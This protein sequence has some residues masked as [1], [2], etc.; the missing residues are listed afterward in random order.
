LGNV[1]G[2]FIALLPLT[3]KEG[4]AI[5]ELMKRYEDL[6]PQL[7]DAAL[8][9]LAGREGIRTIFTL[10]QRDFS[11]YRSEGKRSFVIIPEI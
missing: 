5:A 11:V 4:P 1:D 2:G 6:R 8:V 10:N 9:H 3:G 7:A